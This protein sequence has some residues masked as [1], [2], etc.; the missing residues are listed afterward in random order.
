M[1]RDVSRIRS[2]SVGAGCWLH[3]FRLPFFLVCI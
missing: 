2:V 1:V 3:L